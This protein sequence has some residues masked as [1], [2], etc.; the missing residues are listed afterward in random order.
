MFKKL[1]SPKSGTPPRLPLPVGNGNPL[2]NS[3][4]SGVGEWPTF[5][6]LSV[7][8]N[9][10]SINLRSHFYTHISYMAFSVRLPCFPLFLWLTLCIITRSAAQGGQKPLQEAAQRPNIVFILTDDQDLHMDSLSYMPFLKE[11]MIDRGLSFRRHYCTVALCCPSRVSMWTGKAA[12]KYT[13]AKFRQ[14]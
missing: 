2:V 1:F 4:V 5:G 13:T 9:W 12:R 14:W 11:H 7:W 6:S 8:R 3:K 10:V